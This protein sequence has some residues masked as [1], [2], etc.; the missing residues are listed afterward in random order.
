MPFHKYAGHFWPE[1]LAT[2][3]AAFDATW[4]ELSAAGIDL[5]TAEKFAS[6]KQ[7]LA[8]R[9]L[10]SA[11]AGGVRDLDTLKAQALRSLGGLPLRDQK[12]QTPQAA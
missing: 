10:V 9:I 8:Q 4:Q 6:M 11:T 7:R 1:E 12:T 2:L 3:E 5:S